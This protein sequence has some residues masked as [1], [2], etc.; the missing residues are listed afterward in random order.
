VHK[1]YAARPSPYGSAA[2]TKTR[3][4]SSSDKA[5]DRSL[6]LLPRCRQKYALGQL[7]VQGAVHVLLVFAFGDQDV[8]PVVLPQTAQE[9]AARAEWGAVVSAS[10]RLKAVR[11]QM[12]LA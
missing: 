1:T 10:S 12:S 9:V 4:A 3:S 6:E 8:Y 5:R 11:K 7:S 2:S